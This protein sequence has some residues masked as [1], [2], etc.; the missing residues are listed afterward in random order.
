MKALVLCLTLTGC[1]TLNYLR[2]GVG[3]YCS[4]PEQA[5]MV[6]RKAGEV[7]LYPNSI[8]VKCK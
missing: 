3:L 2:A 1:S 5:R 6:I 8:E 7:A 4:K